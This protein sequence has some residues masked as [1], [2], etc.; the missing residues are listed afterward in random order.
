MGPGEVLAQASPGPVPV[1]HHTL[2][3]AIETCPD[4]GPGRPDFFNS[5]TA[6]WQAAPSLFKLSSLRANTNGPDNV[7]QVPP[8]DPAEFTSRPALRSISRKAP[9]DANAADAN[10]GLTGESSLPDLIFCQATSQPAKRLSRIRGRVERPPPGRHTGV[11]HHGGRPVGTM[12]GP[13]A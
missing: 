11:R 7:L 1:H 2:T 4:R 8:I 13:A 6:A 5:A 12:G 10:Y 3:R 9:F